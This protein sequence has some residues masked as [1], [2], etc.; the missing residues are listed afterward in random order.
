MLLFLTLLA[1]I[2]KNIIAIV[3]GFIVLALAI[4][5]N[6]LIAILMPIIVWLVSALVN[7]LKSI[8]GT[9]GFSGTILV[10]IIVPVLSLVAAWIAELLLK[11]DLNFWILFGL[12]LLGVFVN[13]F[14]KQWKQTVSGK[15]TATKTNLI[16]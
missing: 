9:Q 15:Q 5:P 3:F 12:G 4:A 2:K 14:I 1:I 7:W 8:L 16:G 10:T 6:E 11:P 13:E